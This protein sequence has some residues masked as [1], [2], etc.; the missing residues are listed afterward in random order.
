MMRTSACLTN[1]ARICIQ[2]GI[3]ALAPVSLP[4]GLALRSHLLVG[5]GWSPTDQGDGMTFTDTHLLSLLSAESQA[6]CD[7]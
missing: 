3:L 7:F 2:A 5:W 6:F 1:A 4:G